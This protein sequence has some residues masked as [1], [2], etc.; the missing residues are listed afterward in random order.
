M[1]EPPRL[2]GVEPRRL[3]FGAMTESAL[4]RPSRFPW[5]VPALIFVVVMAAL[6]GVLVFARQAGKSDAPPPLDAFVPPAALPY[7]T[8][9]VERAQDGKLSV[10]TGTGRD[11]AS[12]DIDLP[13]GTR[14]WFLRPGTAADIEPGMLVNV[15]AIPNEVRNSTITMMA[16]A[17]PSGAAPDTALFALA[18]GFFGYETS[19]EGKDR[20][21]VSAVLQSFDG[22]S[23]VTR[24][25]NGPGTLFVDEG[26]PIRLLGAG[27]PSEVQPGDRIAVHAGADGK[28]DVS[29][30]VLVL[31]G[32]AR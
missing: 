14:V 17:R 15:I 3:P 9:N 20:A 2:C 5:L 26:A 19:R 22:R 13:A 32:G 30:G 11:A 10:T 12:L 16:F 4:P 28:P 23:G 29:Q 1:S 6:V 31:T 7:R 8:Y 24:T 25:A 18:D 21:V 27:Q